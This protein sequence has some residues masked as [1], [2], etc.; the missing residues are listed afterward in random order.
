MP[1]HVS[2][3]SIVLSPIISYNDILCFHTRNL[4][5]IL[6]LLALVKTDTYQFNYQ[7]ILHYIVLLYNIL[8]NTT[9]LVVLPHNCSGYA[10]AGIC[11]VLFISIFILFH[12]VDL[13]KVQLMLVHTHSRKI[14]PQ[15]FVIIFVVVSIY[16]K[17][18]LA[19]ATTVQ[20]RCGVA[21]VR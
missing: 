15:A 7:H 5:Q 2:L 9:L 8:F 14:P 12:L 6:D 21:C 3:Y 13:N 18:P 20:R 10:I 16:A 19:M 4:R 1:Y 11:S 17:I